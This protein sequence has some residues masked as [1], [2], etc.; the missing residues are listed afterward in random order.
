ME[1]TPPTLLR[2]WRTNAGLTLDEV[3]DL[4]GY[5]KSYLSRVERNERELSPMA[6]VEIARRLGTRI[7]DLFRVEAISA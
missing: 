3:A 7:S 6:K 2:Q 1:Q 4:T 5:H